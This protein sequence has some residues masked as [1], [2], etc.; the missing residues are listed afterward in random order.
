MGI[1]GTSTRPLRRDSFDK[2][3]IHLDLIFCLNYDCKN[4]DHRCCPYFI[5]K[6]LKAEADVIFMPY[7]YLLDPKSRKA[8]QV[9]L[10]G[11][12]VIFDEAHNLVRY[13]S[14]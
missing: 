14:E 7:N 11:N 3:V 6:E 13:F 4:C 5:S 12:I 8:H 1:Y 9:E 2:N 10:N